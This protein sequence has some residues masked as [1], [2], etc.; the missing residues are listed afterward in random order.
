MIPSQWPSQ[1]GPQQE[2]HNKKDWE[3]PLRHD[4]GEK[5]TYGASTPVLCLIVGKITGETIEAYY[6][7]HIFGPLGMVDSSYDAP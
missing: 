1:C 3:F 2:D 7:E 5:W 6:Q 4:P